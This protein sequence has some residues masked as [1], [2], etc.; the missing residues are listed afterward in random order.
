MSNITK[1]QASSLF[2]VSNCSVLL[3]VVGLD[4]SDLVYLRGCFG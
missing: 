1:G 2:G 3:L 4:M